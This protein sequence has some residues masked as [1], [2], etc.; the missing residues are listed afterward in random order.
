MSRSSSRSRSRS[1]GRKD[2][3]RV[4]AGKKAHRTRMRNQRLSSRSRSRSRSRSLSKRSARRR[5]S[6]RSKEQVAYDAYMRKFNKYLEKLAIYEKK[7]G[8]VHGAQ[9]EPFGHNGSFEAPSSVSHSS[10]LPPTSLTM[11][12]LSPDVVVRSPVISGYEA[13]PSYEDV[14]SDSSFSASSPRMDD[15]MEPSTADY[16]IDE[17]WETLGD[18]MKQWKNRERLSV[19]SPSLSL[20]KESSFESPTSEVALD[21]LV[22][23][24]PVAPLEK[25]EPIYFDDKGKEEAMEPVQKQMKIWDIQSDVLPTPTSEEVKEVEGI[26]RDVK[27]QDVPLSPSEESELADLFA[28]APV[29]GMQ[30]AFIPPSVMTDR[31]LEEPSQES[32]EEIAKLLAGEESPIASPA[33]PTTSSFLRET[34]EKLLS[35]PS[36]KYVALFNLME[37]LPQSSDDVRNFVLT[38]FGIVLP[39]SETVSDIYN[40]V[41]ATIKDSDD[42]DLI[43]RTI[44]HV[45]ITVLR[46]GGHIDANKFVSFY[47]PEQLQKFVDDLQNEKSL[48]ST[49]LPLGLFNIVEDD[50]TRFA[51]KELFQ[52]YLDE[53][54]GANI[55]D[56]TKK[57]LASLI[58]GDFIGVERVVGAS[59]LMA[60]RRSRR[61]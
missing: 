15:L 16:S 20:L 5:M 61:Y 59:A 8:R 36:N 26:L 12:I 54:P 51:A 44:A 18:K 42:L 40:M 29:S 6:K 23:K 27:A 21:K 11:E 49:L 28:G 19:P 56:V 4:A 38:R 52:S 32:Q 50:T 33:S 37:S 10:F 41:R 47:T 25:K 60:K 3:K 1:K 45:L 24:A 13:P 35:I 30:E 53:N 9:R 17:K 2:P 48:R 31:M 43:K 39:S 57:V 58:N 46:Q 22:A 34:E 14:M 7:Y 55:V